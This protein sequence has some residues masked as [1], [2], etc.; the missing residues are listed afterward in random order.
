M[1]IN[2]Y[3]SSGILELYVAG[4]LS[5]EEYADVQ[6]MAARY[7]EIQAEID[8]IAE[9]IA[10]IS[11]ADKPSDA[12]RSS[13]MDAIATDAASVKKEELST[14]SSAPSSTATV[15]RPIWPW[16]LLAALAGAALWWMARS[17]QATTLK[18]ESEKTQLL[19]TIDSLSALQRNCAEQ[20]A[21]FQSGNVQPVLLAATEGAPTMEVRVF[22]NGDGTTCYVDET[23]VPAPPDGQQYQL[24][25]LVGDQPNDL[26]VIDFGNDA[27]PFAALDCVE[28]TTAYAITLE[29]LGGSE[30]PTLSALSAVGVL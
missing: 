23:T 4:V 27:D 20:L 1:D 21:I 9:D 7:P 16:L 8:R 25:A 12:L 6:Q 18:L 24:W 29:P 15:S 28:G 14:T 22:H 30:G 13:I 26:G 5:L 19:A 17:K 11:P 2:T 10:A 3:I